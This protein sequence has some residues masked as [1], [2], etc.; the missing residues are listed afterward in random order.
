MSLDLLK[1]Q[2]HNYIVTC[3][4]RIHIYLREICEELIQK[5]KEPQND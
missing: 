3:V 1:N 5:S 2:N 4:I